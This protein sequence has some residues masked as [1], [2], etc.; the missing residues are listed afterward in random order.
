MTVTK[1]PPQSSHT[2]V[3]IHN[4][5]V[6]QAVSYPNTAWIAALAKSSQP[7]IELE[8]VLLGCKVTFLINVPLLSLIFFKALEILKMISYV[9]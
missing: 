8:E 2:E 3:L 4:N 9:W 1:P 5:F 6:Y 7:L